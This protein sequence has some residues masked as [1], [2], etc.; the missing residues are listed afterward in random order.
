MAQ[1]LGLT[2]EQGFNIRNSTDLVQ[3]MFREQAEKALIEQYKIM[4]VRKASYQELLRHEWK[5]DLNF[6]SS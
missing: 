5:L 6:A 2:L 4:I 3:R 1:A